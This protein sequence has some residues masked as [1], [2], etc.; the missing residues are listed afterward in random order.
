MHNEE[1]CFIFCVS[2]FKVVDRMQNNIS[3]LKSKAKLQGGALIIDVFGVDIGGYV[4]TEAKLTMNCPTMLSLCCVL[5]TLHCKFKFQ[6]EGGGVT[7]CLGCNL[8]YWSQ[9]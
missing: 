1:S 5:Y 2:M 8:A 6:T 7:F 3:F 4:A 9:I